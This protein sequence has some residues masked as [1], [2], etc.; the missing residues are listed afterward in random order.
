[1]E[2][3]IQ[4]IEQR[5][6]RDELKKLEM[7]DHFSKLEFCCDDDESQE[8]GYSCWYMTKMGTNILIRIAKKGL[9]EINSSTMNHI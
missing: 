8:T 4:G 1:M 7:L 9:S 2:R 6:T 5:Q 3:N